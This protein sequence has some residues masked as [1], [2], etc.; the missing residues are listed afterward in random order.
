MM[1]RFLL[2][3]GKDNIDVLGFYNDHEEFENVYRKLHVNNWYF[4]KNF[5]KVIPSQRTRYKNLRESDHKYELQMKSGTQF[6]PV[7]DMV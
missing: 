4:F 3:D 6:I 5:K 2:D 1:L 7:T